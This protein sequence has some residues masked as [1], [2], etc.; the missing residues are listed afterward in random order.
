MVSCSILF[1]RPRDGIHA[2]SHAAPACLTDLNLDQIIDAVTAG[3][4]VYDLKPFFYSPLRDIDTVRY[5]QE[6]AQ[7]LEKDAMLAS[8]ERFALRMGDMRRWLAS[9]HKLYHR[10][11]RA[12]WFL[13]AVGAYCEAVT[14]L[15]HDL[16]L[17]DL[18][19]CGF[20]AF[21]EYV[22]DYA[23]SG[24]FTSL[25]AETT[26]LKTELSTVRYCV[27]IKD[28]LVRVRR[29]ENEPDYSMDVAQTFARF[30]Q[31]SVKDYGHKPNTRSGMSYV[32]AQ[33]LD[34]VARLYPE[35]FAHL[36]HYCAEN[37]DYLDETIAVFDREV[38]FYV[39][40]LDYI[41]RIRRAGLAFCYPHMTATS[42]N[43]YG[44]DVFDLALATKCVTEHSTI[45]CND[46]YLKDSERILVVS[47]P[48]QGGKTTF[49]RTFGQLHYLASLGCPV[50]GRRARL[51]LFDRLFT[52][53]EREEDIRDLRGRLQD[54]LVRIHAI[55][56]EATPSSIIIMNEAFTSTAL[57]DAVFL[58]REIMGR[59][60]ELDLLCVCVTFI[61]ELA[62]LGGKIVSMVSTV[63]PENPTLR[64]YKILRKPA[65]GLA[66]ALS[67]AEKHRL[68][69][70][71]LKE[72]IKA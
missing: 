19:S 31:G 28:R 29:Y 52:H 41:T 30:R 22:R 62:S 50:P 20:L 27:V 49:A 46:F 37:S 68:G 14:G 65:D 40:Y 56:R 63:V 1:Q 61:D 36:D 42:K 35:V 45:V 39:A 18:E 58:S 23:R 25:V 67:I 64:T 10:Y 8:V 5:R 13:E 48:N 9:A 34:L 4:E 69:Y 53:F 15:A 24:S 44:E 33:I 26:G 70:D 2:D 38:Q 21:R 43:V 32:E 51:F 3:R 7:D 66:Y 16:D 11:H 6:V 72:R 17:V 57:Q 12:G 59:I 60:V 55:L 54:D 71:Q 47:G